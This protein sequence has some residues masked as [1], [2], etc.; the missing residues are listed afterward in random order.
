MIKTVFKVESKHGYHKEI[1]ISNLLM[2]KQNNHFIESISN[3]K[4]YQND[5][6]K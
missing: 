3:K 2:K 6:K 1:K 4:F 5:C